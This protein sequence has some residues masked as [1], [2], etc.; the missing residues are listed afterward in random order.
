M[1][2]AERAAA[3]WCHNS[4]NTTMKDL[5]DY[6]IISTCQLYLKNCSCSNLKMQPFF[7]HT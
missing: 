4:G 3:R 7:F 2:T 5:N 6:G 1:Q